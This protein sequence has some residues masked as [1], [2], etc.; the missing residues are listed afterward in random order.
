[1]PSPSAT[2]T[3]LADRIRIV[4]RLTETTHRGS[5]VALSTNAAL[6]TLASALAR[7]GQAAKAVA[8]VEAWLARGL[9]DRTGRLELY[10]EADAD[11]FVDQLGRDEPA[12]ALPD[13]PLVQPGT[14]GQL[15]IGHA[16]VCLQVADNAPID[17]IEKT[18]NAGRDD[19][20]AAQQSK[21]SDLRL[22]P[23]V[24]GAAHQP[25]ER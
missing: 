8:A 18:G 10:S 1:M 19:G 22:D 13:V 25:V 9:Q 11:E 5:Y 14:F 20:F 12:Q 16:P 6:A 23:F 21:V 24:D 15:H 2:Q 17:P 4:A 7:T 3:A